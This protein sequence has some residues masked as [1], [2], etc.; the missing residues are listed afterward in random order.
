MKRFPA[1]YSKGVDDYN[2]ALVDKTMSEDDTVRRSS[3]WCTNKAWPDQP[4]EKV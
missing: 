1:G 2:A 4:I 3:L